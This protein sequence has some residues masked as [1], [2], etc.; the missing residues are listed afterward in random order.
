MLIPLPTFMTDYT[1][2]R[3]SY[4]GASA[5]LTV[6]YT[7]NYRLCYAPIGAGRNGILD[8]YD[9]VIAM[10]AKILDKF[11]DVGVFTGCEDIQPVSIINLGVVND[12]AENQY[13]G[14]DLSFRVLEFVR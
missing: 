4:G 13:Y 8:L 3:D 10:A 14:C 1:M 12:P 2:T 11:H 9:D 6:E 7:L 5:M